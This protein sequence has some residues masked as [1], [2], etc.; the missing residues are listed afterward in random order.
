[1]PTRPQ[2]PRATP[3]PDARPPSTRGRSSDFY[4]SPPWR[5]FRRRV[6]A[7]HALCVDC[8]AEGVETLATQLDHLQPVVDRPDL[9]LEPSNVAPRCATH[10][11]RRTVREHG[12]FGRR[13]R[14][15]EG[16]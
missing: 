11:S 13:R 15:G 3:N 16:G 8:L 5:R 6:L 12:G 1:M 10:H 4:R 7:E 14:W 9:A 2:R